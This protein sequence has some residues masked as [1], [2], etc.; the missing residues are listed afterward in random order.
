MISHVNTRRASL[1]RWYEPLLDAVSRIARIP[2]VSDCGATNLHFYW[3]SAA[4]EYLVNWSPNFKARSRP[5]CFVKAFA[6]GE[7]S[8][9]LDEERQL[10]DLEVSA[11]W[12]QLLRTVLFAVPR[13]S[14]FKRY[15]PKHLL[16]CWEQLTLRLKSVQLTLSD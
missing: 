7:E 14:S 9:R 5:V 16:P 15:D 13:P 1:A 12:L 10:V 2:I 8:S 11:P 6:V 4:C 3:D